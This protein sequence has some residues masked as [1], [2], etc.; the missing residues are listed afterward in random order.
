MLD[1]RWLKC[2]SV[3]R[4]M[5]SDERAVVVARRNGQNES[6]FVPA[7]EVQGERVR[8]AVRE[9]AQVVWATLPTAEAATIPVNKSHLSE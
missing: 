7:S 2:E 8:V 4:G 9:T 3:E 6:F 1:E 5:F